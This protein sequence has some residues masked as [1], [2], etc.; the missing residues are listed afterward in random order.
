MKLIYETGK[1]L[2]K[3][4]IKVL[5]KMYIYFYSWCL[6]TIYLRTDKELKT[7]VKKIPKI[8][9]LYS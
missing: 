2:V 8:I 4:M 6:K 7:F 1:K 5:Y 9:Y 3:K